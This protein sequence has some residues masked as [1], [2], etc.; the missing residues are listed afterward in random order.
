[1]ENAPDILRLHRD[2]PYLA[3]LA[4]REAM[5]MEVYI[6]GWLEGAVTSAMLWLAEDMEALSERGMIIPCDVLRMANII[7]GALVSLVLPRVLRD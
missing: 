4:Y 5:R 7:V 1:M 6:L 2:N 3:A